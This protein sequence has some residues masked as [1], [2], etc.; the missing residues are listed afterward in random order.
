LITISGRCC[1]H[2]YN[3]NPEPWR[4]TLLAGFYPL[5]ASYRKNVQDDE[6]QDDA[7]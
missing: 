3:F 1:S 2:T 7:K 4:K 6:K 5:S